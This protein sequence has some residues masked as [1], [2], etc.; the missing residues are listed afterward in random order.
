MR[1]IF[2][3]LYPLDGVADLLDTIL[4][5]EA[6]R[7]Q[8]PTPI[9]GQ[10]RAHN[11]A[12]TP[13][14]LVFWGGIRFSGPLNWPDSSPLL[15]P[16]GFGMSIGFIAGIDGIFEGVKRTELVGDAWED[17]RDRTANGCFPVREKPFD[18]D[19]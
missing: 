12:V 7:V 11:Q 19:L 5:F 1:A 4:Y 16:E 2:L 18:R 13:D 9:I 15:L 3:F 17:K 8:R 6:G 10:G 14:C